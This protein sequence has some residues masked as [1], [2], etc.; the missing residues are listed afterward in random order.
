LN[1]Y[2]NVHLHKANILLRGYENGKR[3][4]QE[5][6][7]Q[8]YFFEPNKVY[9]ERGV[10]TEFKTLKGEPVY[11]KEFDSVY[12]AREY[13]KQY[14]GVAGKQLYGLDN[15][16]YTFINDAYPTDVDYDPKLIRL[17][18]LD[19]EVDSE[20]GFPDIA[21]ADKYVTAIT[22]RSKGVSY[23]FGLKDY[24]VEKENVHYLKCKDEHELLDKFL[25]A[26]KMLDP[27][28]VTGWNIEFFDI[29]YLVNRIRRTMGDASAK[30]MSPWALMDQRTVEIMG[31][32]YTVFN[33]VGVN[34]IDYMQAY[35]KFSFAQQESFKLDHIAFIELGERK[36]DYTELGFETL[37]E[38]YNGD[39]Q[40]Y[41]NYNIR[42]VELV[43]KLEDKLKF[44]EQIYAIAYDGHV[45]YNDAFTSVRMWDV[46]IHNYLLSKGV[47]VPMT[48]KGSKDSQIVGAYVKDPQVGMHNWV[49]S[50]DLNSLY[51]HLIM[52]YNISPET[53]A[54]QVEGITIDN[55]LD[56][57][58][59]APNHMIQNDLIAA[60]Q[61]IAA[62][63]CV[64][65]RDIQG[66]L[67]TLMEKM[68]NDRVKFKKQMLAA[69]Q[70]YETDKSYEN[71]K[72]IARCH[73]MQLAKKIQLNSAYGALSNIYFRW[74][75]RD[76]AESITK[77]G[78]LSIRW[79]ER[80]MNAY[81]NKVLNTGEHDYVIACDTDSM[82]LDLGEFVEQTCKGKT[83]E[84]TVKYLDNVCEKVFEPFIDKS[85]EEL[86]KY[87]NAF[88]QKM[89]MKREA[90]A[91]KGI[92][93]AKKRYILNVYNNEGVQYAEPKLK[94]SGIEAVRSSTPSSC[95]DNIKK[96]LKLIMT[97]TE[98]D[99]IDFI[100]NFREEF[101]S[102]PFD[103]I[104]FPRT[105]RGLSEYYDA[106]TIYRKSTPIH[107][108]GA[109]IY[110]NMIKQHKLQNKYQAIG[111]GEKIKFC[112]FRLPNPALSNI[113]ST[114]GILP[115]ELDL[116]QY[117]DYDTQFEKSFIDPLTNILQVIGWHHEKR[118]SLEAFF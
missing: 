86:A 66:F 12:E 6:R 58:L 24:K 33:P 59:T 65:D 36:L 112:H 116:Q 52:Q 111:E 2:T 10:E 20:G 7:Y 64:F 60:N 94:L 9:R 75:N 79:M 87:V 93:T 53:Y 68:Y 32:E 67:P 110:N 1:F 34:I 4:Q 69:K 51:P 15:Y 105:V 27:D 44:L 38:F 81:L 92:W 57:I 19:I 16:V 23:V 113:V 46:I 28:V 89:K 77:S 42:D 72:E 80:K 3:I 40:N 104:A 43:D 114:P 22:L 30:R 41:I 63:G 85:Y 95:R 54:G 26:W 106:A 62:S 91:D 35:K 82:Y 88:D 90:I 103:Q 100:A 14:K 29:P 115:K 71:E 96:A 70:R 11:K 84:E 45:N 98:D 108:R 83:V 73:N 107:V 78:Q 109:L 50:F 17:V 97:S 99:L 37:A 25:Q 61:T 101:K 47:V 13:L 8:P 74:F 5:I 48:D 18:S 31:R 117:I 118:V 39:F 76:L 21:E 55:M 56:G 49:V 102:L